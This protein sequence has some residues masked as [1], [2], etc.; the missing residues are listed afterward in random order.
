MVRAAGSGSWAVSA[1]SSPPIEVCINKGKSDGAGTS[2]EL[3]MLRQRSTP[4]VHNRANLLL[5]VHF[6]RR[7]R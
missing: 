4:S 5:R 7:L 1:M 2:P 6:L 3:R